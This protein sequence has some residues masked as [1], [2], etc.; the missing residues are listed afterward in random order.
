MLDRALPALLPIAAL[1]HVLVERHPT[2]GLVHLPIVTPSI[3]LARMRSSS[4]TPHDSEYE[5]VGEPVHQRPLREFSEDAEARGNLCEPDWDL[6]H[7][8]RIGVHQEISEVE[9]S[10]ESIHRREGES[11]RPF[12][13]RKNA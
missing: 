4:P 2:P 8:R 7:L 3:P 6:G 10:T 13:T 12:S 1:E 9:V 11:R 5:L